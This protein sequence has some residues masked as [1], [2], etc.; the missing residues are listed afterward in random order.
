MVIR[1]SRH[2]SWQPFRRAAVSGGSGLLW[3]AFMAL[4]VLCAPDAMAKQFVQNGSFAITGGSASFEFGTY[5]PTGS[6]W[7][8]T[9]NGESMAQWTSASYGFVFNSSSTIAKG[10][11]GDLS[12][13]QSGSIFTDENPA[14]PGCTSN[15]VTGATSKATSAACGFNGPTGV[16]FIGSD[17]QSPYT[18]KIN[19]PITG[20]TKGATYTLSFDWAGAQQTNFTGINTEAWTVS[21]GTVGNGNPAQTTGYVTNQ[22][23]GWTGWMTETMTFKATT[24]QP[25]VLS[26]LASSTTTTGA[27]PPFALLANVSLVPEPAGVASM[28]V[29]IVGLVGLSWRRRIATRAHRPTA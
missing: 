16:N 24:A 2:A 8:G 10:T 17:A 26:F 4:T 6:T 7:N 3:A 1:F 11:W 28:I 20:L 15:P 29:G 5:A 27:L 18:A 21:L 22:S 12:L 14:N 9:Y 23:G 19:Q 13:Y 25:E